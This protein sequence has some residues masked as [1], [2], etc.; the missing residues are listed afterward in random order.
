MCLRL[1]IINKPRVIIEIRTIRLFVEEHNQTV[2]RES[3]GIYVSELENVI[4][5][6]HMKLLIWLLLIREIKIY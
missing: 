6:P 1:L 3:I 2:Y 5:V 4:T